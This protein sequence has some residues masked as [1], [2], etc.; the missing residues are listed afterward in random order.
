M[1]ERGVTVTE[2]EGAS[3]GAE[4]HGGR[5]GERAER[6]VP[7]GSCGASA[8]LQGLVGKYEGSRGR[9]ASA[10]RGEGRS[11]ET[12]EIRVL[13]VCGEA[14]ARI[15][16]HRGGHPRLQGTLPGPE[17]SPARCV[18]CRGTGQNAAVAELGGEGRGGQP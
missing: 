5:G 15:R 1:D 6:A 7:C 2:S 17:P 12:A 3:G 4:K 8:R 14:A 16:G 10:E 9:R 18:W 13:R 11:P